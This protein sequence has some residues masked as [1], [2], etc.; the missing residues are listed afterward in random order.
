MIIGTM[1]F[2][3]YGELLFPK[4]I[5]Y[6]FIRMDEIL[7]T[8]SDKFDSDYR[9]FAYFAGRIKYV[10]QLKIFWKNDI[11]Y[12]TLKKYLNYCFRNW[13]V[14]ITLTLHEKGD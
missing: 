13:T 2:E 6:F 10:I 8:V 9:R 1:I 4:A 11:L 14:E 5:D 7:N 3:I 12:Q